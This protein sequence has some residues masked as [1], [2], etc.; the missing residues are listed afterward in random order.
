LHNGC[1]D[2]SLAAS[3]RCAAKRDHY[4]TPAPTPATQFLLENSMNK[5]VGAIFPKKGAIDL[6]W[7]RDLLVERTALLASMHHRSVQKDT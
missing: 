2:L 1:G 4:A 3:R 6:P 7:P 5:A